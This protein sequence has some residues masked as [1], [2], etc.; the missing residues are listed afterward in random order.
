M[1]KKEKIDYS[2]LSVEDLNERVVEGKE[3]LQKMKFNNDIT[4]V[5]NTNVL[6]EI[7]RVIARCKTELN[8]R[9]N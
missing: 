5:D 2:E 7:R 6:K 4:P 3:K 1:A 8:K 9:S